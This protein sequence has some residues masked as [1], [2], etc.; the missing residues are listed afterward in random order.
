MPSA[1]KHDHEKSSRGLVSLLVEAQGADAA[2]LEAFLWKTF[3]DNDCFVC[4]NVFVPIPESRG[5]PHGGLVGV[6]GTLLWA[7][8]PVGD[9]KKIEELIE[10][11]L[12][13][14]KKGW[15]DTAEV[16]KMRAALYGK[17]DFAGAAAA[18]ATLPDGEHKATLQ[19]EIDKRYGIAKKS[20]T[21]LQEQGRFLAAQAAAKSLLKGVGTKAEWVTEVTPIVT[22][23]DTGS[24]AAEIALDK[25]LDKVIKQL[26]D[27]KGDGAPKQ[28][29]AII[30]SG[31]GTKV[32][33]RAERT[34]TALNTPVK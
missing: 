1:I 34:L 26:R 22:S 7:G 12:A 16:R 4:P 30:K 28:L 9:A 13:K 29:Q 27:G 11:E 32:G 3:P 24:G 14:V 21:A 19:G 10:A 2:T 25:K 17:G 15:G 5:I 6:D 31:Q 20:V 8:H 33:A 23:F 18:I